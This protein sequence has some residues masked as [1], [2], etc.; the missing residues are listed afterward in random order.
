MQ[1]ATHALRQQV[2]GVRFSHS[3]PAFGSLSRMLESIDRQQD[4]FAAEFW[5]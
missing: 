5:F 4:M 2:L 3:H 1:Q